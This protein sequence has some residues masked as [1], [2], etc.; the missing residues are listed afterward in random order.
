MAV[1]KVIYNG[2]VLIDVSTTTVKPEKLA[3]GVTALDATGAL[4]TGN[5]KPISTWGDLV[6]NGYI[7][8]NLTNGD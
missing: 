3:E 8:S 5:A 1:N 6:N 7:W 4:I 2:K